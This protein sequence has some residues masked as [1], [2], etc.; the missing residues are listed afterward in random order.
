MDVRAYIDSGLLE[1][2]VLGALPEADAAGVACMAGN[3]PEVATE[4]AALESSLIELSEAAAVPPP[5]A[6]QEQIWAKLQHRGPLEIS[7]P[8]AVISSEPIVAGSHLQPDDAATTA[9]IPAVEAPLPPQG[10]RV[11]ISPATAPRRNTFLRAAVWLALLGSL[12]INVY[13]KQ[14]MQGRGQKATAQI[15]ALT[16]QQQALS[17]QQQTMSRQLAAF[18][19]ERDMM[20]QPAM[21]MVLMRGTKNG[22]DMAGMVFWNAK[23]K[24]AYVSLTGMPQPPTGKQYQLWAIIAGK[25]VSLGVM[26]PPMA[27]QPGAN[28][29]DASVASG[30]A[31][32]V[33]LEPMG[34]SA[35]P[36]ADQVLIVGAVE[37]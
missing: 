34:G 23:Q 21:K 29:V 14:D 12:A 25:P 30:Q 28:K 10:R 2:Y 36:T 31:F 8:A 19:Q 35:S 11:D 27:G 15:A 9:G 26:P 32:A 37:G 1:A 16:E 6:M 7:R 4:L 18:R 17:Q 22:Q 24:E 20:M 13:L 3:S 33:S 5:A